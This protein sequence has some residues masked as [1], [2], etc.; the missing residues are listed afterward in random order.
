MDRAQRVSLTLLIAVYISLIT[1]SAIGPESDLLRS[2]TSLA[3]PPQGFAPPSRP[4]SAPATVEPIPPLAIDLRL[5]PLDGHGPGG[6]ARL[7][8]ELDAGPEIADVR[9]DFDFPPGLRIEDGSLPPERAGRFA[10]GE[11]RLYVLPLRVDM[12]G[13]FPL[14]LRATFELADG[15]ELVVGHGL[16]WHTR[17]RPEAG[18][19]RAG[20]YEVM[21]VQLEE[22]LP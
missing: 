10:R 12:D 2:G 8:A 17:G 13:D 22:P 9:L 6:R 7:E 21:G 3:P 18:R 1:G 16:N 11:R 19:K 14:R 5:V 4:K 15:R 20:A